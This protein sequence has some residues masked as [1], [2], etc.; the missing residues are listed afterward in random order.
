[1]LSPPGVW[2]FPYLHRLP[3]QSTEA[4]RD[5][6]AAVPW[7]TPIGWWKRKGVRTQNPLETFRCRNSCSLPRCR[8]F[9]FE[10]FVLTP[11]NNWF[12]WCFGSKFDVMKIDIYRSNEVCFCMKHLYEHEGISIYYIDTY[13]FPVS[14]TSPTQP[15]GVAAV[16]SGIACFN[17]GLKHRRKPCTFKRKWRINSRSPWIFGR[18]RLTEVGGGNSNNCW[19]FL[20]K[21]WG[22][23][24]EDEAILTSIFVQRAWSHQDR[25]SIMGINQT[26]GSWTAQGMREN[27]IVSE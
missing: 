13:P 8:V 14:Q 10:V 7:S 9:L 26:Q 16:V 23:S 27:M 3:R 6:S 12:W 25:S 17:W 22:R 20:P 18:P 1:M 19:N 5:E 15:Q 24:W 21:N 11:D 2:W 4:E